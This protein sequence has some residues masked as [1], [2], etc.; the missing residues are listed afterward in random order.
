MKLTSLKSCHDRCADAFAVA[1]SIE[2]NFVEVTHN[3]QDEE[4]SAIV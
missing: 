3:V 2:V 1:A 4:R